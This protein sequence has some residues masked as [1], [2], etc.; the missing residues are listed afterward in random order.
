MKEKSIFKKIIANLGVALLVISIIVLVAYLVTVII[1]SR[2]F[3]ADSSESNAEADLDLDLSGTGALADVHYQNLYELADKLQYQNN[4]VAIDDIM[5]SYV[6]VD[7]F[8]DLCYYSQGKAYSVAG[9]ELDLEVEA[10]AQ[11][12]AL[13]GA[14]E[15]GCTEVY[16]YG[17]FRTSCI[18]FFVP[19][20]GSAYVDGVLSIVPAR[21][22][23]DLDGVRQDKTDVLA[24]ID[25]SGRIYA[26]ATDRDV[27][28]TTGNNIFDYID[29]IT[30]NKNDANNLSDALLEGNRGVFSV[31]VGGN[32]YT[33]AYSPVEEFGD[34]LWLVSISLSEGLIAPELTYIRHIVS[35]LLISIIAIVVGIVYAVLY[36][37]K[38]KE[39]LLAATLTDAVIECPND[40]SFRRRLQQKLVNTKQR[41][42]IAVFNIHNYIYI[43]E[44]LGEDKSIELLRFIAKVI[45]NFTGDDELYGYFGDGCFAMLI[46]NITDHTLRDKINL[47]TKVSGRNAILSGAGL[48]LRYDIGVYNIYEN[49]GRTVYQMIECASTAADRNS[50]STTRVYD[51]FTDEVSRDIARDE[52]IEAIMEAALAN[53]DFRVFV[54]PKYNVAGDRIDS[55]EALVRWFNPEKGDYMFPGEFIPLFETNGFITKLD[56]FVYVE[57]MEFLANAAERGDKVVPVAVNVS[58]VTATADDFLNFYIS[59]KNKYRIPDNFI[60]LELT[61]SFAME[62]DDKIIRIISELHKNGIRCSIDDFGSGYSSFNILKRIRFDELKL[63]AVFTR[64]SG[65]KA[66]DDKILSSM[67]DLAKD[68]NMTVV[69]EGVETEEM[70]NKVVSLGVDVVQGY[71]YAKAISLEEFRIFVNSNTSIKYK[72][73]VK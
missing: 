59:N 55:V 45:E 60:T 27:E 49:P 1:S 37:I 20:R 9:V 18:N 2:D 51:V 64:S 8:G 72:S 6:G 71:Y 41:Y 13:A 30:S 35:L 70:F 17:S 53:R 11:L 19:V 26:E 67:I 21:N 14:K 16:E 25:A 34:H 5:A 57:M 68:M 63:D 42:S 4:K 65:D 62:D 31:G 32:N 52:R 61:E 24:L 66:R 58:R 33:I 10:N 12:K 23:I 43:N 73:K 36:R 44:T 69:Q 56:H 46:N 54:Q 7:Q 29:R 38:S 28:I 15:A 22:I 48:K 3:F 40:E 47:V 50:G 39:T